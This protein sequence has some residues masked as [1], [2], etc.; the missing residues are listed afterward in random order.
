MVFVTGDCH[1][2]FQ[3]FS[4]RYF[5]EQKTMDRND[6]IIICGDFGGVWANTPEERYWL[7]WLEDRPF[8]TLFVD[9][10]HENFDRLNALPVHHWHGGAVHHVRPHVIHLMR[11]QLYEIDGRTFF[12]MGG[13]QSH[14]VEDGILDPAEPDFQDRQREL[15]RAGRHR[16]RVLGRSWWPGELP[17]DA[18]YLAA[19]EMLER[20]SWKTDY[21]ITH[22]APTHIALVMNHH[23]EA[24]ALSD[25]LEM[26]DRRLEY[27]GWFFGHF[28]GNRIVSSKHI[29]LWEQI[30]QMP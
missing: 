29:L 26:V 21:V 27:T 20:A 30:V 14:D 25:F 22:C 13:A 6:Y 1:G 24:D 12:T 17:S 15:K 2:N 9:G 7:D 23:N 28:H 4:R 3:R 5:P 16:F 10:N 19:M 11:G 8:T 18:E